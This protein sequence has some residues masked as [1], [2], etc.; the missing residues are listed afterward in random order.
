[1]TP[2]ERELAEALEVFVYPPWVQTPWT[3]IGN[4]LARR[5]PVAEEHYERCRKL[6]KRVK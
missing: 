6:L 5:C 2:L 4:Q 3:Q 1:M